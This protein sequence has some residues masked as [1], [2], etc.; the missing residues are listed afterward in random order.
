MYCER[1]GKKIDEALNYCNGCGTS[2]KRETGSY[3]TVLTMMIAAL[4]VVGIAGLGILI[5]LLTVLLDRVSRPEPVFAFAVFY[6]AAWFGVCFMMMRQISKLVDANI[7][8]KISFDPEKSRQAGTPL[9]QLP[10]RTTAQLEEFREPASV[11]DN[12]TRTLDEVRLGK[13]A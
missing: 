7:A 12:T 13:R 6:L 2:L 10:P 11:I 3:R 9:V 1:C 8:G 4:S 5:G